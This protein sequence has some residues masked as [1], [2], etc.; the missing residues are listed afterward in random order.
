MIKNLKNLDLKKSIG[1][2]FV[3]SS[4]ILES[5]F[6]VEEGELDATTLPTGS[7]S[8]YMPFFCKK[9]GAYIYCEYERVPG[10]MVIRTSSL[11]EAQNFPPQAHVFTKSKMDWIRLNDN[12]PSFEIS[13]T[14][15]SCG[16]RQV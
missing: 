7:G 2:A 14:E 15:T 10:V 1:S 5:C 11:D 8:V 6:K 16:L 12:M 9:C 13:M 3:I 4:M